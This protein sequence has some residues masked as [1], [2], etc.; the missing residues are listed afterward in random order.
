MTNQ[1]RIDVEGYEMK[2]IEKAIQELVAQVA[3][4]LTGKPLPDTVKIELEVGGH[5]VTS[6]I[7]VAKAIT[8]DWG[9]EG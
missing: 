9:T 8:V 7:E 1:I 6:D 4:K 3:L 2:D 5:W